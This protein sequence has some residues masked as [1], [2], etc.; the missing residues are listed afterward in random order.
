MAQSLLELIFKT[1]KKGQGGKEAA[2]ELKSVKS[3][4]GEVSSGLL[5]FNAA[6][7]TAAGAIVAIGGAAISATKRF[8]DYGEQIR[9]LTAITGTSAE[10][11]SRL[12][13]AFD[14]MGISAEQF[15]TL[16]AGAAKK[17]FVM[18]LDNVKAL[19]DEYNGL[20]T[21][22]EKNALLNEKLGKSGLVVA[23]AFEEGSTAIEGY[24]NAVGSGQVLTDAE[25]RNADELR[26]NIDALSD[27]YDNLALTV[28]GTL[29][30]SL[31]TAMESN[32]RYNE[33]MGDMIE[34]LKAGDL[35]ALTLT[36]ENY[37][38]AKSAE[39]VA[40]NSRSA[41]EMIKGYGDSA[42][43]TSG[44]VDDAAA[45]QDN[46]NTLMQTYTDKMLFNMAAANLSAD[47]QLRL[48]ENM[49][50]VDRKTQFAAS[51][52]AEW[53]GM[54]DN[55]QMS[56][57][58]YERRVAG[59][60][61]QLSRITSKD[62]TITTRFVEQH[63]YN[64]IGEAGPGQ[65]VGTSTPKANATDGWMTVPPGYPGDSYL[66]PMSSGE[67]YA[68]TN[69]RKRWTEPSGGG[70]GATVNIGT[71]NINSEMDYQ[72]FKTRLQRDIQAKR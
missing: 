11:T 33:F 18:T 32:G 40:N 72:T 28:G 24:F 52:M 48:A 36:Y 12:M 64:R 61:D 45:A 62:V 25:I 51:M 70:G 10:E 21:T 34:R 31:N 30:K 65:V 42:S 23:K 44:Q 5:G 55:G 26:R 20:G 57:E 54:L 29:A 69:D 1:S 71:V 58:E 66:V 4:V 59:L 15:S 2:A 8:L 46:L 41:M 67:Q 37:E 47:A 19:A 7:L 63:Y 3:V 39:W 17:G 14:D 53:K 13:Q 60:A 22:A 6:N 38:L 49:G 35:A 16:A 27:S 56:V 68:V 43:V 9:G 50:L